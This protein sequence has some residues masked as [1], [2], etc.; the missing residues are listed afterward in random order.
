MHIGFAE[1]A[2]LIAL[3]ALIPF[4]LLYLIRPR[5][6]T[7]KIP[8]LMFFSKHYGR[9][10]L[11][12]FLRNFI[13][14]WLF[15]IQLLL[16]LAL[17]L[18]VAKPYSVYPHDITAKNTVL[19][20]DV[21]ASM[22]AKEGLTTRFDK[23]IKKARVSLGSKNTVI[24]AK[25]IPLIALKEASSSDARDFLSKLKPLDT[26]SRLGDAII[27]A[28][29]ALTEGRVV[30]ISDFQN[31]G[32]QDPEVAKNV[33][34]SK[35]IVVDFID[36][37]EKEISNIGFV[38][39]SLDDNQATAFIKNFNTDEK[40]INL[41]VNNENK[42]LI[43]PGNSVEPYSF[44]I[45]KGMTKLV[46]TNNDDF[47]V[48]NTLYVSAPEEATTKVL[49]ATNNESIFLKNALD[50][51]GLVT[52]DI[53]SPPVVKTGE[54]DVYVFHN[55]A[56]NK[57]LTGTFEDVLSK[58]EKGASAVIVAQE[59]SGSINYGELL[60]L[61]LGEKQGKA[62]LVIDQVN[63]FTK[64]IDFG[65]TVDSF[66]KVS[67]LRG[68]SLVSADNSSLIALEERGA[69][70]IVYFG[71]L[72]SA[73]D[74]KF[75]PSYPIF[76]T[77]LIKYL[78]DKQELSNLNYKTKD[79]LILDSK[80]KIILPSRKSIKK[81]AHLLEEAGIYELEDRKLAVNLLDSLESDLNRK[82]S[83]GA[84]SID[85]ELRPVKENRRYDFEFALIVIGAILLILE[86]V[87]IKIRGDI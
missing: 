22:Q 7:L 1:K 39:L 57:I 36:V 66:F 67:G 54:H 29:E 62:Y 82:I 81:S 17:L 78:T 38:D 60:P 27:L 31:T 49:L 8:S 61:K 32:G 35:G 6:K 63:R 9:N 76:W 64:N 79:T 2:G 28:G 51:S 21:S 42:Q 50:A 25:G 16:L 69:G 68:V 43:I 23:A 47:E 34:A 80:Q 74:F 58:V 10:K 18:S 19:V 55:I 53:T 73:S 59:E 33:V 37:A 40:T 26:P 3:G 84:K 12:S 48:D 87:Y 83:F 46:I 86:L 65:S 77:E 45:P 70:K 13:R 52:V 14:D 20:I 56:Q 85:Y 44:T 24:L 72:E 30:V 11:L 4:I 5:P 75:S 15:I 71:F 41:K